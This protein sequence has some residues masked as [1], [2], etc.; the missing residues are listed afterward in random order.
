VKL[1][2]YWRSSASYRVRIAL[3]LK[4]LEY[5]YAP[6]HLI[7]DG[8]DQ[9]AP[10]YAERNPMQQVPLLEIDGLELTQSVAIIEYLEERHPEPALLPKDAATRAH[11]RRAVEVVN[12][13]IQPLQ[14]LTVMNEVKRLGGDPIAFARAANVRGLA[15]LERIA[16]DHGGE[17]LVGKTTTM[18]DVFLVPQ[19]YSARR[20]GVDLAPYPRLVAIDEAL[21]T[22]PAIA[23]AHPDKQVDAE[24]A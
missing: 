16:T 24:P 19:M 1:Y 2:S 20:F 12:S 9:H 18:A 14:N 4:G 17:R 22:I 6:I 13:G 7:R 15:A 5:E 10:G 8:G 21:A 11:V 23:A 3:G